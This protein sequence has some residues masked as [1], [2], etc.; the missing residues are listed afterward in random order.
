RGRYG[1]VIGWILPVVGAAL[2]IAT[3][4]W[5]YQGIDLKRFLTAVEFNNGGVGP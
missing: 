1:V 5:L 2:A 3:L 4:S